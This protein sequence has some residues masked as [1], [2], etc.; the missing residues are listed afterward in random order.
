[1]LDE[2][3]AELP[4]REEAEVALVLLL[5]LLLVLALALLTELPLV[6]PLLLPSELC[7]A[8]VGVTTLAWPLKSHAESLFPLFR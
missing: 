6:L 2:L 5:L 7:T 3:E 8:S 4:P 1:M